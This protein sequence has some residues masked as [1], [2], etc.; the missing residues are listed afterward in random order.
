MLRHQPPTLMC[1]A[2]TFVFSCSVGMS[3]VHSAETVEQVA[4]R[5]LSE[6]SEL[7]QSPKRR[8]DCETRSLTDS[9]TE[10]LIHYGHPLPYR[11]RNAVHRCGSLG[12]L[13]GKSVVAAKKLREVQ[14][15]DPMHSVRL[16]ASI[17]CALY[18]ELKDPLQFMIKTVQ[19]GN[20]LLGSL[21]T[22]QIGPPAI[23][24]GGSRGDIE[25]QSTGDQRRRL[26]PRWKVIN[27]LRKITSDKK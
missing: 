20:G 22:G 25:G 2:L 12:D 15:Q 24:A 18:G 11:P 14:E 19:T 26:P 8:F 3:T 1:F 10:P 27:A 4:G 9:A 7:L 21:L 16:A 13:A 6:Y 5:T 17:H 23:A